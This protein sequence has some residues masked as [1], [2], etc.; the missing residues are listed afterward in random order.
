MGLEPNPNQTNRTRTL[1]LKE[2]NRIRSLTLQ[3]KQEPE[4]NR[5]LRAIEPEPNRTQT[6]RV[7]SHSTP[8]HT[9][10]QRNTTLV[11]TKTSQSFLSHLTKWASA[12]HFWKATP[13]RNHRYGP[14]CFVG[15]VEFCAMWFPIPST[16]LQLQEKYY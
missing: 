13:S 3:A 14:K 12:S 5:T 10:G 4:P 11:N 9:N 1:V 7:L 2:P 15:C 16:I 6:I 8:H